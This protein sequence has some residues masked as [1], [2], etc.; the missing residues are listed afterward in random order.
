MVHT[1]FEIS[2]RIP[3]DTKAMI[4]YLKASELTQ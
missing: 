3:F 4:N 2:D 1:F